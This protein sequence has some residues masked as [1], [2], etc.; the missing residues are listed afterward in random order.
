MTEHVPFTS[1]STFFPSQAQQPLHLGGATLDVEGCGSHDRGSG[2]HRVSLDDPD[3]RDRR[4]P[5]LFLRVELAESWSESAALWL[6]LAE[7]LGVD[8]AELGLPE[9]LGVELAL[10]LELEGVEWAMAN[11]CEEP[12]RGAFGAGASSSTSDSL[13]SIVGRQRRLL[14]AGDTSLILQVKEKEYCRQDKAFQAHKPTILNRG[15][16]ITC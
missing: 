15:I 12:G 7:S 2:S 1:T 16:I 3:A 11:V 10:G 6:E 13:S 9:S 5:D 8:L 4:A 14:A